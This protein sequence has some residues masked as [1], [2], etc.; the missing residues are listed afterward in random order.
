[1]SPDRILVDRLNRHGQSH[2]LRWWEELNDDERARLAAEIASIDFDQLDRLIADLVRGE[3]A[4]APAASG[5]GRSRSSA[6]LR[7]TASEWCARRAGGIG[8][9]AL[10]AGEV[11]VILVA[12]GSGTRLGYEGPKGTF[13]IGPVSSASLFQIHAEKIVALGRGGTAGPFPSTS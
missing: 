8:A 4:S 1:M 10:A 9:D 7:R 11:G 13:P 6:C 5:S 12:G 3:P 2:L